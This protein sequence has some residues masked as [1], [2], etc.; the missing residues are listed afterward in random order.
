MAQ[1]LSF[2]TTG[3]LQRQP[4]APSYSGAT[5][6]STPSSAK[7]NLQ[8]S[9]VI[10]TPGATSG[11]NMSVGMN[12]TGV[13][14]PAPTLGNVKGL[15]DTHTPTTPVKSMTD[16]AGNTINFH[17]PAS[18]TTKSSGS[19]GGG[20][21]NNQSSTV[22][23]WAQQNNL[24]QNADGSY[25]AKAAPLTIAGQA[26]GVLN[27]G[28]QTNNEQQ[29]QQGLLN[30]GQATPLEQ[31]YI[32]RVQQAQGL[33]NAG[34]LGQYAEAGQNAS[35]DPKQLYDNLINAPDLAGRAAAD[36]GLFDQFSNIY[37]SQATQGLLAANTIAG[38]GLTAAQGA[39]TGA[40]N[41]ANR[42][43]TANTTVLGAVAPQLAGYN[44]Q[45]FNP[46]TGQFS[47]GNL[48]QAV[49]GVIQK[50][51]TGDM[52][53]NDAQTALSGYG[54]GGLDALQ[55]AL[56]PGFNVSQSNTLGAQQGSV[57]PAYDFA[58]TA[59][60][61]LQNTVTKLGSLQGTNIPGYNAVGD[62]ISRTTGYGSDATRQ[63]TQAIQEARAAYSQLLAAGGATPTASD[64]RAAAAIPDNAT[65]ND[66]Q[67]A[68][69]S[70]ETLGQAKVD[71][72]GNPGTS[73]SGGGSSG[74][75]S[76]TTPG[77]LTINP[78]F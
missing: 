59:L 50:L 8:P 1:S 57:K 33:K 36:K 48:D 55:K 40:Q 38:R 39:Y 78:N 74:G 73:G 58:K 68:I 10:N 18:D 61:N 65:P 26:P 37:G 2:G 54:Q 60:T 63:Y 13:K 23:N 14:L 35:A 56:P 51:Q 66:I 7:L 42:G 11:A 70:L 77:G 16:A 15:L 43:L 17:T 71:I 49:S 28:Q 64:S 19:T 75:G 29:T 45:G 69:N 20:A 44:Q 31:Q 27:A 62:W 46:V 30:A 5:N 72:Y 67:A 4:T 9:P 76:I 34:A 12:N 21:S 6:T 32:D 24:N 52:T 22:S 3:P 25:S 53:Y 41:Q 47:G